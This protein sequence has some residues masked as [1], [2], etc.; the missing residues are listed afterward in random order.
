MDSQES[1][2]IITP[3]C[4]FHPYLLHWHPSVIMGAYDRARTEIHVFLIMDSVLWATILGGFN[5]I[6]LFWTQP[7][8][9]SHPIFLRQFH[10]PRGFRFHSSAGSTAGS[11]VAISIKTVLGTWDDSGAFTHAAYRFSMNKLQNHPF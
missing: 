6:T 5:L 11:I 4:Q 10:A 2:G 9:F 1:N 8:V 3:T 7:C